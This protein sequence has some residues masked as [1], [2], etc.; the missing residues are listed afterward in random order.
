MRRLNIIAAILFIVLVGA[1]MTLLKTGGTQTIQTKFLGFISPFLKSGSSIQ[2]RVT[3]LRHNLKTLDELDAENKSLRIE[4]SE[5]QATNQ[6]LRGLEEENNKL[7]AALHYRA[8]SIFKLVPARVVARDASTWWSTIKIDRGSADGIKT[9]T[10]VLTEEGLV[11]KTTVVAEHMSTVLLVSDENCKVAA[12]VEGTR[13]QGIMSGGRTSTAMM[14]EIALKFL[15]KD[16]ALKP[17]QKVYSSGVG[18]VFPSGILLGA[19]RDFKAGPLSGQA[20]IIP[21]VHLSTLENVFI[22]AGDKR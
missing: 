22:V 12:N 13:E 4:N 19:V 16:A 10:P 5:L 20:T 15:S 2:Q 14:P 1:L 18:G 6:T 17:G 11:G 7:R 9:D 8:R 21:A 3:G